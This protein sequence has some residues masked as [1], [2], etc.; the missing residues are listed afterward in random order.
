MKINLFWV[1]IFAVLILFAGAV[2]NYPGEKINY[3]IFSI[4]FNGLLLKGF[5]G[6][7]FYFEAFF[8]SLLW[9]GFWFKFS[10]HTFFNNYAFA[11]AMGLFDFSPVAFDRVIQIS[12]LTGF[13]VLLSF[14]VAHFFFKKR[15]FLF[16]EKD[17]FKRADFFLNNRKKIYLFFIIF[18]LLIAAANLYL[19]IYQ[20]GSIPRYSPHFLVRGMVVWLLLTG[21]AV[22]SATLIFW[23]IKTR[24][25]PKVAMLLALA[26][27]FI[28]SVT[29]LS[30]GF[31]INTIPLVWSALK[32]NESFRLLNKKSIILIFSS[33]IVLFLSSVV[34]VNLVRVQNFAEP[35][36]V[37]PANEVKKNAILSTLSMF[38]DRWVGIE[39][40]MSV[41]SYS[42]LSW[43]TWQK[44]VNEKAESS[45]TSYY[46]KEIGRSAYAKKDL[47]YQH[48][49]TT[50]GIA[51]FLFSTGSLSF[52][53]FCMIL[54]GFAG[55]LM[56]LLVK[57]LT[58]NPI[59]SALFAQSV[60][61]RFIHFGYLPKQS[62]MYFAA[63]TLTIF[64]IYLAQKYLLK[65]QLDYR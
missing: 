27:S 59:L 15:S 64:L 58:M 29:M 20:R 61:Y 2:I 57:K 63:F 37:Y 12:S 6:N 32:Q 16:L 11:E 49:I 31:I 41:S 26:E 35:G 7:K 62:Y 22:I 30:R 18:V 33:F 40:I 50:P 47:T 1:F 54:I 24:K 60:A 38:I 42:N 51:A 25:N 36:V 65:Q 44:I 19:G 56:E 28:T 53:F 52:L 14:L 46:D 17:V 55:M 9:L 13:A 23:E 5:Y 48:H 21:F 8:S 3:I 39:G 10:I 43:A 34:S 4:I 45:G